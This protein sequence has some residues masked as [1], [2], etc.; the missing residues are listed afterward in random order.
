EIQ[1]LYKASFAK[2]YITLD[3]S[4]LDW[5]LIAKT[6]SADLYVNRTNDVI[7]DYFFMNKGQDLTGIIYEYGSIN[8]V[9]SLIA[10]ISHFGKVWMGNPI[11]ET[12]NL[13]YQFFMAP[14]DLRLFTDCIQSFTQDKFIVRNINLMKQEVFFD[15][16][17]ETLVLSVEEFL[18]GVFGPG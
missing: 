15:Y 18:R 2:T 16:N 3:R 10:T 11:V 6:T 14:G 12:E 5:N 17:E 7:S 9:T 1:N 4:D 13:Q 8:D